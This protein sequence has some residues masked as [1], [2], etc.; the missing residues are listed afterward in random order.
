MSDMIKRTAQSAVSS[1][2]I[3]ETLSARA[4]QLA[5]ILGKYKLN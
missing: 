1:A 2:K 5:E 3:G 4:Q